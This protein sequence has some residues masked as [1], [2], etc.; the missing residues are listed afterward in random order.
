MYPMMKRA[1]E[2][3]SKAVGKFLLGGIWVYQRCISPWLGA[4]CRFRPTCS[5][6]AVEAIRKYGPARGSL[7]AVRRILRCRPGIPGGYDP[8]P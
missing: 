8:V 6:Y 5:A 4:N 2:T 7:M 3:V 1:Q